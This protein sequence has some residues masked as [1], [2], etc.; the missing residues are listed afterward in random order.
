[1]K[2]FYSE[3]GII[4]QTS[5]VDTPKQ[6]G[7]VERKHRHIL[8]VVRALQFQAHLPLDFWGACVLTAAHF[9]KPNT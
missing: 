2:K 5:C 7:R 8:N 9:N 4:H 1:M 6:N 3:K